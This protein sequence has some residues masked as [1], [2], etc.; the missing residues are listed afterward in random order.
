VVVDDAARGVTR[1]VRGRDIAPSTATQVVLQRLLGLPEFVYRHHLLFLEERGGKLAKLHGSVSVEELRE[2]YG[3]R[4]LCGW[5]A[6]AAGL[7]AFPEPAAPR[8]LLPNFDWSRVRDDDQTVRW[9]GRELRL[10]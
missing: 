8:E 9:N 3:P 4:E 2:A 7:I 1:I 5:L 10:V 6:H